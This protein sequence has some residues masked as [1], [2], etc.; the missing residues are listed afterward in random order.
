[1]IVGTGYFGSVYRATLRGTIVA[2]KTARHRA[3]RNLLL[4]FLGE[5][6]T[7][8]NLEEHPHVLSYAGAYTKQ[9]YL[10][11]KDGDLNYKC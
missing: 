2:V 5:I 7:M 3:E 8:S 4:A 11:K 10:G 9:L 1:L 6:K